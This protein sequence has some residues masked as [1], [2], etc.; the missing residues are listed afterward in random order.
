[1]TDNLSP[2]PAEY[3]LRLSAP[4]SVT[5]AGVF[6][7]DAIAA[8][9]GNG[10]NFTAA[11]LQASLPLWE[12]LSCMVDHASLLEPGRSIKDFGGALIAPRWAEASQSI[13]LTL[14]TMPPAGPIIE[15]LGRQILA[16]PPESRP[17]VGFSADLIFTAKDKTV[18]DILRVFE[19]CLVYQPAR[20]GQFVRALNSLQGDFPM[21]DSTSPAPVT[22]APGAQPPQLKEDLLA[23]KSLLNVHRQQEA[24]A[25]EVEAARQTRLQMC[26]YLLDSGLASS[27][28]PLPAQTQIRAHFTGRV[29]E[30]AELVAAIEDSRQLVSALTGALTVNGPGRIS[31]HTTEEQLQLAVNDLLGLAREPG[32]TAKVHTLTGIRELYHMLT[33]DTDYHG[34]YYPDRLQLATT[35]DFTGLVKNALN[36]AVVQ[37]WDQ[38]GRAGYDWWRSIVQVEHFTT[39]N[40][41]TGTIVGTVGALPTV[42]EGGE[43]TELAVGDSPETASFTKYGGYIPLTMELIDRDEVKALRDYPRALASTSI[44]KISSLIAAIFTSNSAVG[45]TM[46]DGGALFNAT[47]VTTLAGHANLLTTAL[48]PSEWEVVSTAIYNQPMLV[49]QA[50]GYYGTGAKQ[51][52]NPKYCVVPRALALTAKKIL[53]PELAYEAT[54]NYQNQQRGDLGDVIT[55]PEWTDATDWAAVVDPRLAPA[56]LIGERFGLMPEIYIAGDQLSPA[57]FMND[58]H[59]LKVRL[60]LA[61]CVTDFRPLH[62]SNVAG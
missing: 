39:L 42:A 14:Q 40:S 61:V 54:Y 10:W 46:A 3:H 19:V 62:K 24:M 9:M 2:P 53:Y 45:P 41:I 38:Y 51:A 33:G 26:G 35:A 47:A 31:L 27:R 15:E 4:A 7:I 6:E 20:G 5:P 25:A 44:R 37:Q 49:K 52:L 58:E 16:L 48:S 17:K 30:P 23:I 28:L 29:F 59:R 11:T 60:F 34:G 43:Y 12:G 36:K 22:A 32:Q 13:R 1:M 50:T 8:G 21:T 18:V 56:I 55:V 57:V